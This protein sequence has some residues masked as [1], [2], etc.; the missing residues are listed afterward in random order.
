M[1]DNI[2][3]Q[4]K[5]LLEVGPPSGGPRQQQQTANSPPTLTRKEQ[6]VANL[7]VKGAANTQA[8][9]QQS[10]PANKAP[11]S[12]NR[13]LRVDILYHLLGIQRTFQRRLALYV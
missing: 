7:L 5:K 4:V 9:N 8:Q 1:I 10:G 12:R 3:L 6:K 11:P 13:P 2:Y